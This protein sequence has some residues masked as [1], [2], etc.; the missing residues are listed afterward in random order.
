MPVAVHVAADDGAVEDVEGGK[1]C[2]RAV[3]LVIV[4]HG[5]LSSSA[6]QAGCGRAPGQRRERADR[7]K[8]RRRP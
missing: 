4:G 2:R 7:H 5:P 6:D 3:A 8:G 1:Q